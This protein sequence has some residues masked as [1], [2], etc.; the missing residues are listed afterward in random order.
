[1]VVPL[2]SEKTVTLP[3]ADPP[4]GQQPTGFISPSWRLDLGV[5]FIRRCSRRHGSDDSHSLVPRTM[6]PVPQADR[7]ADANLVIWTLALLFAHGHAREPK[8]VRD[9]LA[10]ALA[11]FSIRAVSGP[12][13]RPL[14]TWWIHDPVNGL[15]LLRLFWSRSWALP[16][17]SLYPNRRSPDDAPERAMAK[18]A[19]SLLAARRCW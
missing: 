15:W 9:C 10:P 4:D 13:W 8:T 7:R 17:V 14:V 19:R 5:G 18:S 6:R 3:P 12:W 2:E 16:G 1:M 11:V